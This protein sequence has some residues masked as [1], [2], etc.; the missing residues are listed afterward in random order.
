VRGTVLYC[1]LVFVS[2][3]AFGQKRVPAQTFDG[4]LR[5]FITAPE[6]ACEDSDDLSDLENHLF[7]EADRAVA[8]E[9]NKGVAPRQALHLLEAQSAVI[10]QSWD[11]Q[12]RFHFEV[13]DLPPALVVKMTYRN[14][15]RFG[16]FGKKAERSERAWQAIGAIG[17]HTILTSNHTS[18]S[19]ELVSLHRGPS[20]H[21]RFLAKFVTLGCGSGIG[22]GYYAYEWS[23]D[24]P[25]MVDGIIQVEGAMSQYEASGAESTD[26]GA[27]DDFPPVGEFHADSSKLALPYCWHS[28]IDTW[29][30]P[31]LCAV[32]S[33]DISGDRVR[34]TGR[35]VNRP[36]LLPLAKAIDYAVAHDYPAALAYCASP[37]VAR[38]LVANTPLYLN[39]IVH[40]E[41]SKISPTKRRIEMGWRPAYRFETEKIGDRWL[42]TGFGIE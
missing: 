37:E 16:F 34:F 10:N 9:L 28:A 4:I 32:D 13:L 1:A 31:N 5:Q 12:W 39:A 27:E 18:D 17:D 2:L 35:V 15:A 29:A 26:E 33:W 30:N 41:V 3:A 14:R 23:P 7:M 42:V 40:F 25:E 8:A 6:S 19:L 21:P 11:G 20:Q 24:E 36:D 38:Q 22:V